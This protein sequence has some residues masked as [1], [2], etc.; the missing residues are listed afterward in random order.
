[1]REHATGT[2]PPFLF[3]LNLSGMSLGDRGF[4]EFVLS[5]TEEPCIAH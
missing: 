1:L 5:L 4:L 3:A 2:E